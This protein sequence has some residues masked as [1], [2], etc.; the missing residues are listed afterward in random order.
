M[1]T[2]LPSDHLA[3]LQAELERM[4]RRIYDLERRLNVK[5]TALRPKTHDHP[6]DHDADYVEVAGD[7]MTGPLS[8]QSTLNVAGTIT[9]D[10]NVNVVGQLNVDGLVNANND[11][12]VRAVKSPFGYQALD[13]GN[14]DIVCVPP[15]GGDFIVGQAG[16]VVLA[17]GA[18]KAPIYE[19]GVAGGAADLRGENVGGGVN[20]ISFGWT[21]TTL[22]FYVDGVLVKTL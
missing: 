8:V 3:R 9:A 4:S 18:V 14:L 1:T 7:T 16:I 6:H 22:N 5:Q 19:G 15:T 20:A 13:F 2:G 11:I 21:G 10:T 17:G 12:E